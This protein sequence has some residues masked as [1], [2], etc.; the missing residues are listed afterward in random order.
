MLPYVK[1][2]QGNDVAM[3]LTNPETSWGL[4]TQNAIAITSTILR[5]DLLVMSISARLGLAE[6]KLKL[7][8]YPWPAQAK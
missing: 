8:E 3:Q 6:S 1:P 7:P 4:R 2:Q 5:L